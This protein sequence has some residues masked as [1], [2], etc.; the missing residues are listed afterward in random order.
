MQINFNIN[1]NVSILF[2]L[3]CYLFISSSMYN[4][5]EGQ[6]HVSVFESTLTVQQNTLSVKDPTLIYS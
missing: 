5:F 6:K 1:L 3:F 2:S 4:S